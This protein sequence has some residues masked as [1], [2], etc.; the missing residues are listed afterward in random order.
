MEAKNQERRRAERLSCRIPVRIRANGRTLHARTENLSRTGALL[1]IPLAEL[2]LPPNASITRVAN[3]TSSVLGD[4]TLLELH[5]EVL[6]AL[7]RRMARPMR[8]GRGNQGQ[9]FV[10]VGLA[11]R[12]AL[13]GAEVEFL[14]LALPP[15]AKGVSADDLEKGLASPATSAR[16]DRP[17]LESP[18]AL[19]VCATSN[20]EAM[21][22][23]ASARSVDR[24]GAHAILE[25]VSELPV[26]PER[27]G[28]SGLLTALARTYGSDP[29]VV[30]LRQGQPVWS[31]MAR[32]QAVELAP[33]SGRVDLQLA[34][35][36]TL[37]VPERSRMQL[38]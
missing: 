37:T 26:L 4:L 2:G 13:K 25:H 8:I 21:P 7:V 16:S 23:A 38:T 3:E 19:V 30:L 22:F 17:A 24:Y 15:L 33:F 6:G 29:W 14:G 10:E 11:F 9:A 32:L 5:Y 34:F 28:V 35:S 27:P 31:G 1:H 36:R 20:E 12:R 18:F